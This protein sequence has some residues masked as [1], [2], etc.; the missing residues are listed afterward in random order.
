VQLGYNVQFGWA[1]VGVEV[2][3][4]WT[5]L[6]GHGPCLVLLSCEASTRW[7]ADITGRFGVLV[8]PAA[9][10]YVRGGAVL[11]RN[12]YAITL[13]GATLATASDTRIGGLIGVGGEYL[14]TPLWSVFAEYNYI[15]FGSRSYDTRFSQVDFVSVP[16]DLKIDIDQKIHRVKFG[17]NFH[18]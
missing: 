5:N 8:T 12:D 14:I 18:F 7:M 13:A 2:G 16:S 15:D 6:R 4:G 9:L 3:G 1:V 10:L 11:A 17:V